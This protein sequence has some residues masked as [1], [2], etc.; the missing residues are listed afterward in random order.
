MFILHISLYTVYICDIY[1]YMYNYICVCACE[2]S[3]LLYIHRVMIGLM[4]NCSLWPKRS[5]FCSNFQT[6]PGGKDTPIRWFLQAVITQF[7][8]AVMAV[9]Y[10]VEATEV[11]SAA[12]SK[13][14]HT[15]KFLQVVLPQFFSAVMARL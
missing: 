7:F 8:C 9:P 10:L 12:S 11:N 6:F 15:P 3:Q 1:I 4:R 13:E 2:Y 14:C 5:K